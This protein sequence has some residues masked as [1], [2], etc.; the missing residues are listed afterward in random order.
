MTE[1]LRLRDYGPCFA[2]YELSASKEP[3]N[4]EG[5]CLALEKEIGDKNCYNIPFEGDKNMLTNMESESFTISE[6]EVW[7]VKYLE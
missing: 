3:F 5:N 4:G 2:F 7:Q 1:I 6:L